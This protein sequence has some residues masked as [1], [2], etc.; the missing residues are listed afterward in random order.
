[1]TWAQQSGIQSDECIEGCFLLK[2]RHQSFHSRHIL[3]LPP[4]LL[5]SPEIAVPNRHGGKQNTV[6]RREVRETAACCET[7]AKLG[8]TID[9]SPCQQVSPRGFEPL[10][11]GFGV[12]RTPYAPRRH[13]TRNL[14]FKGFRVFL[15]R[16]SS[17]KIAYVW[18]VCGVSVRSRMFP[19]DG[20]AASTVM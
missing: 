4:W 16:G 20:L 17:G 14:C 15:C 1:M 7:V 18:S 10:T 8:A 6:S 12:C 2:R 11:F 5:Q 9:V 3:F 13:T 19:G